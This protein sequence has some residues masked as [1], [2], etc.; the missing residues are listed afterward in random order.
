MRQ[1]CLVK[2]G[3]AAGVQ[4]ERASQRG[5]F[6]P[7]R[8]FSVRRLGIELALPAQVA[9][10]VVNKYHIALKLGHKS[11]QL[12]HRHTDAAVDVFRNVIN[13][14]PYELDTGE[15]DIDKVAVAAAAKSGSIV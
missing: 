5:R 15:G 3:G 10:P 2:P 8:Q 12:T 14:Q 1:L 4:I 7:G 6:I 11:L 9:V 13:G